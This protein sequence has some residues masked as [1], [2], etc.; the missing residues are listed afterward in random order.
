MAL[1]EVYPLP[2]VRRPAEA[3]DCSVPQSTPEQISLPASS[4]LITDSPAVISEAR[5]LTAE[6]YLRKGYI[7]VDQIGADATISEEF[8]PYV[9]DSEY[10]VATNEASEIAATTRKIRFNAD[11]GPDSFPVWKH[12]GL[13]DK[14]KV[15]LIEAAGLEN[16]VEISAL[17][18][19][20]SKDKEGLGALR[21][22]RTLIQEALEVKG[23]GEPKEKAFIMALR[24]KLYSK[25]TTYFDGAIKRIGPNLDYPG[26][27]VVPAMMQ[28]LE[29]MVEVIDAVSR[30]DN[31][32]AATH[33]FIADFVL[34]SPDK[35]IVHDELV[36]ALKRNNM[37]DTLA[38]YVPATDQESSLEQTSAWKKN[39]LRIGLVGATVGALIFE[40]G[41]GNEAVRTMAAF[42]VLDNTN[43]PLAAG[44]AVAALTMA[45]ETGTGGLIA[46][47]LHEEKA[48]IKKVLN[49][50]KRKS[51]PEL[52]E[53]GNIIEKE[54]ERTL[55]TKA[56]DMAL[57]V[58][59]G[60]GIAMTKRHLQEAE[61]TMRKDMKRL[62]GYSAVGSA[63]SGGIAYLV[64]G[65]VKHA[66]AVGL[67]T[68]AEY[69]A[70]YGADI[71]TW[72]GILGAI[73]GYKA[74]KNV[75]RKLSK[76]PDAPKSLKNYYDQPTPHRK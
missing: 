12:R 50:F 48:T 24:P 15:D 76:N 9:T 7:T 44:G 22:Y 19:K 30:A 35:N 45:I 51:A 72:A 55:A 54:K 26:E 64:T 34:S 53:E 63:L 66:E 21:L 29:G 46:L 8:D 36:E 70:D 25:L 32:D 65:G 43:S 28:P 31:P 14:D 68:P 20:S 23:E 37:L 58:S 18:K 60:P 59:V 61:P 71:R 3:V 74:V 4:A 5:Q 6:V 75:A 62:L 52:D 69:V 10:Y 13:F 33:G 41:P 47:G 73:Y 1:E 2:F 16:C 38:K 27:E 17:A 67:E 56:G 11:K 39:A 40:Q 57:A 49:R 42:D